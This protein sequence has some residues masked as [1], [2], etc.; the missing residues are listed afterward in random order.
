[1]LQWP[2]HSGDNQ[3]WKIQEVQGS[4][5]IVKLVN[6]NTLNSMD[7]GKIISVPSDSTAPGVQLQLW[8]DSNTDLQKWRMIR[9]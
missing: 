2:Y 6:V 1:L 3:L 8:R 5:D 4:P 9:L 7:S